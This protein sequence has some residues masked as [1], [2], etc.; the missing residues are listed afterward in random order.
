MIKAWSMTRNP[1]SV[2]SIPFANT[3][4]ITFKRL[5]PRLSAGKTQQEGYPGY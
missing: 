1:A 2:N 3:P 4:P 5:D